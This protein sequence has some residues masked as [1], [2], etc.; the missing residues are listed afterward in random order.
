MGKNKEHDMDIGVITNKYLCTE[1]Y[2]AA[3]VS[4][5]SIP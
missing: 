3:V 1:L 5:F 2:D 4:A